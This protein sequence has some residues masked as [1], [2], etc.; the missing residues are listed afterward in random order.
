MIANTAASRER[1]LRTIHHQAPD[2]VPV[3]YFA[4]PGVEGRLKKHFGLADDD[5]EGLPRLLEVDF[6]GANVP[7]IGPPLHKPSPKPGVETN[8]EF[9]FRTRW[10]ANQSGGYWDYCDYPLADADDETIANWPVPSPDDYDVERG[11]AQAKRFHDEGFAV[12]YGNPGIADIMNQTGMLIGFEEMLVRLI[13][14][15]EALLS[16]IDRRLRMQ[17]AVAERLLEGARGCIDIFWMGEDLGTQNGALISLDMYREVLKPRHA[18]FTDLAKSHGLPTMVHSCG[19][20][21]WAYEDLI[22]IGVKMIDTLQPEAAKMQPAYLKKTFGDRLAFHGCISTAGPLAK[23]TVEDV[24]RIVGETL[25]TMMPG[26]GYC[27]APTHLIQDDTPV[28]N[29]LAM[30]ETAREVGV[31]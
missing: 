6:R 21:S 14:E 9:G 16:L 24:R 4:N 29:V 28:E 18:W 25:E 11:I 20:S 31:Y 10:V 15:D 8:P 22:D 7:Y 12:T 30:Y 2:R 19:S 26:G 23:G 27:L 13:D 3:N 5:Y 1:V 17:L